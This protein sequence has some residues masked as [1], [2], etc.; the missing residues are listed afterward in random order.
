VVDHFRVVGHVGFFIGW[1]QLLKVVPV[2]NDQKIKTGTWLRVRPGDEVAILPT[3][4]SSPENVRAIA[5]VS[6][7]G[8]A[9][10]ELNNGGLYFITDGQGMNV[11]NCIVP[12][13][14]EHRA[15]IGRRRLQT[16]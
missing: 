1:I 13:T 6:F 16:A 3:Q 5:I 9:L 14:E 10:I 7:V 15:A 11:A 8:S 4:S 2:D 12:V